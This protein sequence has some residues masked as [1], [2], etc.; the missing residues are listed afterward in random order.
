MRFIETFPKRC[1]V[2][3]QSSTVCVSYYC[4]P[5]MPWDLSRLWMSRSTRKANNCDRSRLAA[6]GPWISLSPMHFATER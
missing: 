4:I 3:L 1:T 6:A 2:W 5:N